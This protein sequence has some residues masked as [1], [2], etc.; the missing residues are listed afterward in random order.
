MA[1][2]SGSL[3]FDYDDHAI[4]GHDVDTTLEFTTPPGNWIDRNGRRHELVQFHFH[5]PSEHAINGEHAAIEIHLVHE[6]ADGDLCVVAVF[7]E[8]S[9]SSRWPSD[10]SA[11][12]Q[13]GWLLPGSTTRYAYSGSLTTPPFTEGVDWSVLSGMVT[14]CREWVDQFRTRYGSNNR[15]LQPL[16][17]RVI[18]LG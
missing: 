17:G 15:S 12:L 11:P 1:G 4:K 2:D 10:L 14:V 3:S 7:G 5:T 8:V 6:G 9:E 16:N 13:L 18:T